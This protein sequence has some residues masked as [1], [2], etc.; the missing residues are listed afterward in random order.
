MDINYKQI[1]KPMQNARIAYASCMTKHRRDSV[2]GNFVTVCYTLVLQTLT[3]LK[4]VL[5][6]DI[7][8]GRDFYSLEEEGR[9]LSSSWKVI[10]TSRPL[11][12]KS[13]ITTVRGILMLKRDMYAWSLDPDHVFS[14]SPIKKLKNY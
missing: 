12:I 8:P 2:N 9:A 14:S 7:F 1:N 6:S 11:S 10:C 5:N 13:Q 3:S 4:P